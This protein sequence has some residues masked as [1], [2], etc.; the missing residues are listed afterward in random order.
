MLRGIPVISSDSGGLVEAKLGTRFVL[1]VRM[2]ERYQPVFDEHAMPLPVLEA[3][4][5]GPWVGAVRQLLSEAAYY[6]EESK[7]SQRAA[8]RF[9][10]SLRPRGME[11]LLG[12]LTSGGA[13]AS[14]E[15]GARE[16]EGLRRT[17]ELL[18]PERRAF[19]LQRLKQKAAARGKD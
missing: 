3:Q 5:A 15:A 11:D 6:A 17:L 2:I 13:A 7:N 4:D 10:Q 1:P 19:L 16:S 18:S 8:A 9:V 12:G 14:P